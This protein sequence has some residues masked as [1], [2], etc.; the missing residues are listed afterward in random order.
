MYEFNL[1]LNL[2]FEQA[3]EKVRE[4]LMGEQL[5]VV[6]EIDV[7][8]IFKAKMDKDIAPYRIMGACNP[9]LAERVLEAEPNAGTLLPCNFVMRAEGD[10]TVVSFMDPAS[11]L[12]LSENETVREIGSEA[13]AKL[14]RVADSLAGV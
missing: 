4:T 11:V 9:K 5:G 7:Q 10:V 2:P 6:S 14:Q 3:V 13:R 8:A 1:T 12:A